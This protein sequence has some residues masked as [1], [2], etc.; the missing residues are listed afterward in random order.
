VSVAREST[1]SKTRR[2]FDGELALSICA[3]PL[4]VYGLI[5]NNDPNLAF[6]RLKN[7]GAIDR[8]LVNA[9]ANFPQHFLEARQRLRPQT[10]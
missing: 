8:F 6:D 7:P 4:S 3:N 5:G 1:I 2:G 10:A 9:C